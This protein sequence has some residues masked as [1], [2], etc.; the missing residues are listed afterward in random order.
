MVRQPFPRHP[1]LVHCGVS[2]TPA[3][4]YRIRTHR[5]ADGR[6]S[7]IHGLVH[8]V[9]K[10]MHLTEALERIAYHDPLTGLANRNGLVAGPSKRS[11][12]ASQKKTKLRRVGGARPR[13]IRGGQSPLRDCAQGYGIAKPMPAQEAAAWAASCTFI[14]KIIHKPKPALQVTILQPI[15]V[16][17]IGE[18]L[19]H[20][21]CND[22]SIKEKWHGDCFF[23]PKR[24][25]PK[26]K[27]IPKIT[28]STLLD[29]VYC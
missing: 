13:R 6:V 23:A 21:L 26:S 29:E 2:A 27:S 3:T 17:R 4:G 11:H 1:Q 9:T 12:A 8:D 22:L 16:G 20:R 24:S 7:E 18:K 10:E 25:P 15:G 5:L 14:H 28:D 19:T